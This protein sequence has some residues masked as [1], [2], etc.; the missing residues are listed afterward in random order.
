MKPGNPSVISEWLARSQN[1]PLT[2]IAEFIDEYEHPPCR[3][4]DS[5]T[6]TLADTYDLE[7]C[8]RHQAVLSLDRLLPHRSRIRNLNILFYSSDPDWTFDHDDESELFH[9]PF[10]METLPNLQRLDFRA[11]HLE[12]DRYVIH[13]PDFLF[14][15]ELPHLKE[16]KY[17]GV[18]GGLTESA[19]DLTSCEI[20][21]WS[22]SAGHI[23]IYPWELRTLFDNNKTVKSLTI[24][25]SEIFDDEDWVPTATPMKDLEFL[26][27]HRLEDGELDTVLNCIHAPQ[28]KSL[29]T[30]QLSLSYPRI[31]AIATDGSDHTFEFSQKI[32]DNLSFYPLRHFGADITSLRLDRGMTLQELDGKPGLYDF[33][34]SLDTVQVLE[35]DGG[36]VS[37]RTV[38]SNILSR[39]GVF[40]GLKVIWVAISRD[41]CKGSLPLLATA[42]RLRMEEGNP[43]TAIEPRFAE[44]E[45]GL[46]RVEW[47]RHYEAEGIRNFL[48]E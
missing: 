44:G 30:V 46:G 11:A 5:V 20:G 3:Y 35:F 16:L 40:P 14:G 10:F 31:Q 13:I 18:S 17:L 22:G 19:K 29:D 21:Y 2:I 37:V 38:L 43:L 47:E 28:F 42:L 39:T 12:Q 8:H 41:S 45:D 23:V 7:V 6:A 32:W 26:G 48:S 25:N 1:V 24:T 33:F 36:V 27:I 4:N 15:W 9:H 34:Q